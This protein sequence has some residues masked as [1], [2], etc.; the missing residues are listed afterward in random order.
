[1]IPEHIV[2]GNGVTESER[3][4]FDKLKRTLSDEFY[5]YHGLRYLEPS[6]AHE[7]E[8]DF[9]VLHPVKGMLVIECK[10]LGVYRDEKGQWWR[11]QP[12]GR[13]ERMQAPEEQVQRHVK[14][15]AEKF[16]GPLAKSFPVFRGKFPLVFGWALAFPMA[17]W[18][19]INPPP[20]LEREVIFDAM[21]LSELGVHVQRAMSFYARRFDGE[22]P[23]MKEAEFKRFCR[24]IVSP[25]F[26]IVSKLAPMIEFETQQML[27]LTEDQTKVVRQIQANRLIRVEGGAG[28]G[29]T[30]LAVEVARDLAAKG[31]N[32]L[33]LC[34][35]TYLADYLTQTVEPWTDM[36]GSVQATSFHK[37]CGIAGT[38]LGQ[39]LAPPDHEAGLKAQQ[40][41]W[42][43]EAPLVLLEAIEAGKLGGW[44]AIIVD[45]AQDFA[46]FW[47]EVLKAG[48]REPAQ[49]RM[50]VFYDSSQTIFEHGSQVPDYPVYMLA[51]NL[52]NTRSIAR[53]LLQLVAV[54]MESHPGCPT[55]E[56]PVIYQQQ[57]PAKTRKQLTELLD[58]LLGR[59]KLAPHNIAILTA[60]S[61]K[62]SVLEGATT[63]GDHTI[64]H[65]PAQWSQGLLH[66]SISGFKGLEA[67]VVIMLDVNA[68]DERCS[69]NA[70]YV[71]ASRARN[72]LYVFA[73]GDWL[74]PK[75]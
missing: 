41:Y 20:E 26:G 66:S 64:V 56:E 52:R 73:K 53:V 57:S 49:G 47:W 32:V 28:T 63:L 31:K 27:R 10:G 60:R 29:K 3:M 71:G 51:E 36:A 35:N 42:I 72:R 48:L 70:R 7:G 11:D 43:E 50:V 6:R 4:I 33:L 25:E 44:D 67:E 15:L 54:E 55:G 16:R 17:G 59:E 21:A 68:E 19:G 5:V 18:E 2:V 45:E 24:E 23:R 30:V 22:L 8:A 9:L 1:M 34:F 12:H 58:N 13:R 14:D 37:L 46:T 61:P 75:S 74:A 69:V 65:Q 38:S 39:P 62:N 40:N